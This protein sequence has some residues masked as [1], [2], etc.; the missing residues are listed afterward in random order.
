VVL[1]GFL[2]VEHG[3]SVDSPVEHVVGDNRFH[4]GRLVERIKAWM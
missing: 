1:V 4:R 2:V 3:L